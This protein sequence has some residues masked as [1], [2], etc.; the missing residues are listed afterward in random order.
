[1]AYDYFSMTL[2][3]ERTAQKAL[4]DHLRGAMGSELVAV[5]A[6][7]L[8]FASNTAL[9]LVKGE[10]GAGAA[11]SAPGVLASEHHS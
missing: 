1:M 9:V 10:G 3:R 6:P 7:V 8:G 4:S 5:F 2:G 11:G